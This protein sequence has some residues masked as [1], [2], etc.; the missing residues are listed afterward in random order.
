MTARTYEERLFSTALGDTESLK[1]IVKEAQ[2]DVSLCS[3]DRRRLVESAREK[4][5][6]SVEHDYGPHP[7]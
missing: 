6:L 2:G 7:G 5:R 3:R 4:I 1:G